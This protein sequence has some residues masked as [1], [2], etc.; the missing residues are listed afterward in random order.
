PTS[1]CASM[2][3]TS[4]PTGGW[5][6][7]FPRWC[8]RSA[9]AVCA[10]R[11]TLGPSMLS[12]ERNETLTRF[13]AGTP[14]GTLLRRYWWPVAFAVDLRPPDVRKV[15]LLGTDLALYRLTDGSLH[16]LEDRCPHRGAALSYGIVEST[17][18]R[19][20]Y[21]GW[22]FNGSG[23]CLEQPGEPA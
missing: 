18:I 23:A 14:M 20:P 3:A 8:K 19:C 10:R 15:R 2:S 16:V 22:L 5:T 6:T 11:S 7:S 4:T 13:G 21:H 12:R 9:R 1:W 17:G